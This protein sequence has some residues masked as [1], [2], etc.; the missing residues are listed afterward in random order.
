M[1]VVRPAEA[2]PRPRPVIIPGHRCFSMT[3]LG[4]AGDS[5]GRAFSQVSPALLVLPLRGL[6]FL[7]ARAPAGLSL[8][9]SEGKPWTSLSTLLA[10]DCS[11]RGR[12]RGDE[13]RA[14]ADEHRS[15]EAFL[16]FIA[17]GGVL[18]P[19]AA[20]ASRGGTA[21]ADLAA[22]EGFSREDNGAGDAA[23]GLARSADRAL[24]LHV[25]EPPPPSAADARPPAPGLGE[26]HRLAPGAAG[27]ATGLN[28]E[29]PSVRRPAG[30][31][32]FFSDGASGRRC[33]CAPS[34]AASAAVLR[35]PFFTASMTTTTTTKKKKKNGRA[36]RVA[37]P[38]SVWLSSS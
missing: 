30:A 1:E 26:L 33:A 35:S 38:A 15:P 29:G 36:P 6:L 19:S 22:V 8:A 18:C 7:S 28:R 21:D 5:G 37:P 9:C 31:A 27:G 11:G 10:G 32:L 34:V 12:S 20:A 4:L 16:A 2:E 17:R 23:A 25:A 24:L 3:L 14:D 13:L